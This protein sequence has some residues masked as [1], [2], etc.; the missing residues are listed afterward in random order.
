MEDLLNIN[1][2]L[3]AFFAT[4]FTWFMT[5]AGAIIV[6][7]FKNVNLKI[8]D[9]SLGF[10]SG[11]MIAASFWSL[12]SPA[13]E[14]S[15]EL[16]YI[17]FL[18]PALG[19]L[20]G[21]LFIIFAD[22]FL[23]KMMAR[24]KVINNSH[25]RSFLLVFAITLHNIPE[26]LA[27]GVAFGALFHNSNISVLMSAIMLAFSIGIQNFPEGAAVSLPLRKE[28]HSIKKSLFYGQL[29]GLV[30]PIAGVIGACA[31]VF[32]KSLLPFLLSFSAGA[33]ICV[34]CSEL[35]P[36]SSKNHKNLASIGVILGFIIM[37]ILDVSLG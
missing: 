11:I 31:A 16:N 4:L 36:E 32:V 17:V 22:K 7:F 8:L 25:K 24:K 30:E 18:F 21:G 20:T 37:M 14:L 29:S 23:N 6:C 35:I 5:F 26:G 28:G 33:M 15:E 19:F 3:L 13:I 12:L 27:V 1:P 9:V 34:V 10:S 2:I